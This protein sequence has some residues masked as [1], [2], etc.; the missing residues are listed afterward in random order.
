MFIEN[1]IKEY[2]QNSDF[3]I[4][5]LKQNEIINNIVK[6]NNIPNKYGVYIIYGIKKG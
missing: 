6:I 4:F 2:K 3:G 5:E 1:L